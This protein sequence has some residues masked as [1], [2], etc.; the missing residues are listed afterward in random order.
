MPH[1][2]NPFRKPLL[3]LPFDHRASFSKE[4]LGL[5]GPLTAADK[6]RVR[7]LKEIVFEAFER[8]V[9][10]TPAPSW[11]GVL[12][13]EEYGSK[14]LQKAKKL[15]VRIAVTT[16]KSG[17]AEYHFEY[18]NAFLKHLDRF[19]PDYA[20]ALVR[21]NPADVELNKRQ[22][23]RL[24]TLSKACRKRGYGLLFELLV[25]PTGQD[26]KR[27]GSRAR[28]ESQIRPRLTAKAIREI[29]KK[30]H[31]DIWKLEGMTKAGWK[32]A[33]AAMPSDSHA[34]VLG[35]GEG[36]A[37]VR[38]WLKDAATFDRI[39]G[40]AV[41]RTIF[42]APLKAY[43]A[44]KIKREEAVCRIAEAFASDVE[45]WLKAKKF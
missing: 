20:K 24:A 18:G 41:G 17:Q 39:V 21:Y 9:R 3:I 5:K 26:L 28:F 1:R 7:E 43:A 25:P 44:G 13:D 6:K 45:L 4:L 2:S 22:L 35:R 27:A 23:A 37:H 11:F 14:L 32:L 19:K 8:V 34:I 16:E 38:Q 15:G 12:I 31:V 29:K 33:L 42:A 10:D 36:V 40:F 30:V